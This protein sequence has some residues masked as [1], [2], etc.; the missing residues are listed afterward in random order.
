MSMRIVGDILKRAL[1]PIVE[2]HFNNQ[3]YGFRPRRPAH[4]AKAKAQQ[5]VSEGHAWV[6]GI[7][8]PGSIVLV[9]NPRRFH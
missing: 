3:S 7:D 1:E 4:H 2:Y 9:R 8:R 6:V 5:Y